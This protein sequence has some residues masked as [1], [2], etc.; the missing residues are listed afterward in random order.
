M[1]ATTQYD[2]CVRFNQT[3]KSSTIESVQV[4]NEWFILLWWLFNHGF[5]SAGIPIIAFHFSICFKHKTVL[6]WKKN[7][8]E[9]RNQ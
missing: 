4:K 5:V 2:R 9:E 7:A 1:D 8:K 6:D 3:L